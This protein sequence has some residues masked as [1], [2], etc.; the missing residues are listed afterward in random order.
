MKKEENQEYQE[1]LLKAVWESSADAMRITDSEGIV[2][3]VNQAYCE[4]TGF[5]RQ[6]LI[7]TEFDI[8][9]EKD[10]RAGL[11]KYY[12]RFLTSGKITERADKILAFV[13]GRRRHI[14]ASYSYI[15]ISGEDYILSIFRDITEFMN[16]IEAKEESNSKYRLLTEIAKVII[17][18][19]DLKGGLS[20]LNPAK[21]NFFQGWILFTCST[22]FVLGYSRL[23]RFAG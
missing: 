14:E 10:E 22:G 7:G 17:L 13:S 15:K 21:M 20:Y 9:Y 12:K 18:I 4:L 16:A 3:N 11:K 19:Y 23:T 2:I 1:K 6:N 8:V 5:D